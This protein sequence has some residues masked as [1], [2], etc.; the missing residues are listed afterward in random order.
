MASK[1]VRR[2]Q[3]IVLSV[4]RSLFSARGTITPTRGRFKS[5]RTGCKTFIG[6]FSI[7]IVLLLFV[8]GLTPARAQVILVTDADYG[9]QGNGGLF[10]VDGTGSRWL[11]SDFG[12]PA[13]GPTGITPT[14][15]AVAPTGE[16]WVV[17]YNGGASGLGGL[18]KV[19]YITGERTLV[20]D[21]RDSSQGA[22][23]VR[24]MPVAV[25]KTGQILV[26]DVESGMT[27]WAGRLFQV[28][29]VTGY[30][31]VLSDFGNP[32]KGPTASVPRGV[33]VEK[34]GDILVG[35]TQALLRINPWTGDRTLL[36]DLADASQGPI[37]HTPSDV[38][39]E[40]SGTILIADSQGGGTTGYGAIFRVDPTNGSRIRLSDFSD[41]NQGPLGAPLSLTVTASGE[42]L[43]V[44]PVMT[45]A[46]Y[47][48]G[49]LILVDKVTG[50]R[51]VLSDFTNPSQGPL[52]V[53]PYKVAVMETLPPPPPG[54]PAAPGNLRATLDIDGYLSPN[55][56]VVDLYWDDLSNNATSFWIFRADD[57]VTFNHIVGVTV[58]PFYFDAD[59]LH[60]TPPPY[61]ARYCYKVQAVSIDNQPSADS[62]VACPLLPPAPRESLTAIPLFDPPRIALTWTNPSLG[63]EVTGIHVDRKEGRTG[64]LYNYADEP[65]YPG[66][67]MDYTDFYVTVD[68]EYCY[69]ICAT[70]GTSAANLSPLS[71]EVCAKVPPELKILSSQY[72]VTPT[73]VMFTWTTNVATVGG[74]YLG[75]S[76]MVSD[77]RAGTSH[78]VTIQN[79]SDNTTYYFHIRATRA[80]SPGD[81]ADKWGS[82]TTPD[83][84]AY[85][86]EQITISNVHVTTPSPTSA[87]ITWRTRNRAD[88][89]VEYGTEDSGVCSYTSGM[90][91]A[92]NNTTNH[93][94]TLNGLAPGNKYCFHLVATRATRTAEDTGSFET[95]GLPN[96][97]A[98]PVSAWSLNGVY[99][100]EIQVQIT[101]QRS[102]TNTLQAS[103]I[104]INLA[105]T[106]L[107]VPCDASLN[108]LCHSSWQTLNIYGATLPSN[109]LNLGAGQSATAVLRFPL[110]SAAHGLFNTG[111]VIHLALNYDYEYGTG[112]VSTTSL[113]DVRVTLPRF[114]L[115]IRMS[116]SPDFVPVYAPITYSIAIFNDGPVDS[117]VDMY[118]CFDY[119][120]NVVS[121]DFDPPPDFDINH[122]CQPAANR[123]CINC[124]FSTLRSGET[125]RGT[126]VIENLYA[127]ATWCAKADLLDS[128]PGGDPDLFDNEVTVCSQLG[129]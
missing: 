84:V 25:D 63:D 99:D 82:F 14:G 55:G 19:D 47:S 68:Q 88:G 109:P 53:H 105:S 107:D 80:A 23:G 64:I 94:T 125:I 12:D 54:V 41:A 98:R 21:F 114:G 79:L 101:N 48:Y 76:P 91:P 1:I 46:V 96:L 15:V 24:P 20:S 10:A 57:G 31:K 123:N 9:T 103:N 51:V 71:N 29:P 11:V 13:Q 39:V 85:R 35:A 75:S 6:L 120:S 42:I 93:S 22:L 26:M 118:L 62:N 116:G 86:R 90:L 112:T 129:P 7:S 32:N 77:R 111:G 5:Y 61:P 43:A 49:E 67:T 4:G 59:N 30:R 73:A 27:S 45:G 28:N 95:V 110:R 87:I 121:I 78:T 34:L 127:N 8:A 44:L 58:Y 56:Y 108:P 70:N 50:A 122:G 102:R 81:S 18:F 100:M 16:I 52:G 117:S 104:R 17:D 83:A 124:N 2:S 92:G 36:S 113:I 38:A 60:I 115:S 33:A 119:P 126:V 66:V 74:V 128:F 65:F 69:Q 40:P 3:A 72:D 106:K 37:G 97:V 89:T